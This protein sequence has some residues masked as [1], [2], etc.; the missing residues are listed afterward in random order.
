VVVTAATP[1]GQA[2]MNVELRLVSDSM[3]KKG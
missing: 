2:D 3:A 1:G